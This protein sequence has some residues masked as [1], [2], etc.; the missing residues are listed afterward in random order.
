MFKTPKGKAVHL[1]MDVKAA[2]TFKKADKRIIMAGSGFFEF[3]DTAIYLA[4]NKNKL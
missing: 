3:E 2:E 4:K 1:V